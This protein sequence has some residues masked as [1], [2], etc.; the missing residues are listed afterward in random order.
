METN[1]LEELGLSK[2]GSRVYLT[3][4]EIGQNLAGKIAEKTKIN[5][6]TVYD[7]LK[8]LIEK[9]FVSY[10]LKQGKKYFQAADPD[11]ILK[12]FKEKENMLKENL[13]YLQQLKK[14]KSEKTSIEIYEGKCGMKTILEEVLRTKKTV[15]RLGDKGK[16]AEYLRYSYPHLYK[17]RVKLGIK[18]KVLVNYEVKD[19]IKKEEMTEYRVLPKNINFPST[20]IIFG[21]KVCI[22]ISLEEGISILIK[23]K[24]LADTYRNYFNLMWKISKPR[25]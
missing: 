20:N 8:E 4:L 15:W 7:I 3:L 13:P 19:K 1:F 6:T 2:K 9:G 14:K 22:N 5:R 23:S 12:L 18:C 11:K 16:I 24:K 25:R 10:V 21:N 17:K